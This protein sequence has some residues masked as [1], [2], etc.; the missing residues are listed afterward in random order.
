VGF[1]HGR[2]RQDGGLHA[3]P[4]QGVQGR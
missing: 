2:E 3:R 1:A 4:G